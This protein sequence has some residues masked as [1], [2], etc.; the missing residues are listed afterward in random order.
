MKASLN[1]R[2]AIEVDEVSL[3]NEFPGINFVSNLRLKSFQSTKDG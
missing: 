1:I 2:P 3:K